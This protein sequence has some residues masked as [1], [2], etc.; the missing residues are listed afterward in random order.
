VSLKELAFHL[1]LSE[2][3]VSRVVND[4]PGAL[5]IPLQ[6]RERVLAA[7]QLLNYQ[8]NV[9]ARGLRNKRSQTVSVI[10][11]EI[12]DGYSTTV[13][14]GIEDALLLADYFYFVVS[15]RHRPE[16]LRKYP[17]LL[18]SRSVEGIIAVDT[19]LEMELPI[20]VVSVSGHIKRKAVLNI[21]LDHLLAAHYALDH[22]RALGHQNIA[23]IKGQEFSSDT[24]PRWHAI[25]SVAQRLGLKIAPKLVV[26][27]EATGIGS[28]PGRVATV[29]LLERRV[30]FTAIFAFND[31]SAIGAIQ[32]LREANLSVPRD[33]SVVGFD[34]I[35][36]AATNDPPLTT[37]RQPLQ[38][39]GRVAATS[40]LQ[41]LR[42]SS[43]DASHAKPIRV[44]PSFV[45]RHS[46]APV[47]QEG[48]NRQPVLYVPDQGRRY[49]GR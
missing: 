44:L 42:E 8:P 27:L 43:S 39:M 30:P 25:Q 11:P 41:L 46:T 1:G 20:P 35:A 26:Q 28:E 3:T 34:D 45:E 23:V 19:A 21:E 14:S 22:L 13:L 9:L 31:L 15:H 12:S 10:V 5:R 7:A 49:G 16:L 33:V 37:V 17:P 24:Q 38:E 4:S 48:Q 36:S 40:L 6:T 18:L 29:K 2:T 47:A 32:A